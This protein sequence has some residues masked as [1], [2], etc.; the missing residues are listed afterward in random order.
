M[1]EISID[2]T[3][4]SNTKKRILVLLA[5]EPYINKDAWAGYATLPP[6]PGYQPD[7]IDSLD[8]N[9]LEEEPFLLRLKHIADYQH[10]DRYS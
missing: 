4:Q 3:Q 8:N 1:N 10:T 6:P 5:D 9:Q 7:F 2:N